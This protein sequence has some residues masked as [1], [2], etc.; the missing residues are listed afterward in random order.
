MGYWFITNICIGFSDHNF[1]RM[2]ILD[3]AGE[4]LE[5]RN[6]GGF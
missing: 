1:N 6:I 2:R 3:R 5:G 4:T